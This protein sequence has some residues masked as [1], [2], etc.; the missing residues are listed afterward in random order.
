MRID[1]LAIGSQGDVRPMFAL[2]VG[3]RRAGHR[4]RM[5]TLGGFE[6]LARE[7]G[8]DHLSIGGSPREIA[9]TAAGRDWIDRRRNP[10]GFFLG[11]V[12]VAEA[13]IETGIANYWRV[14]SD[15]E[16]V[17]VTSMGLPVGM[18]IAERLG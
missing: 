8:F 16:A 14:C 6:D 7:R 5:V 13:F 10:V 15:V 12:R 18:H 17:I 11:F 9:N 1:I 4:V 3:L 2:G